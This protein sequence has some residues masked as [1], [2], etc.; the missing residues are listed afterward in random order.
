MKKLVFL[1]LF[2]PVFFNTKAE[3]I[4]ANAEVYAEPGTAVIAQLYKGSGVYVSESAKGWVKIIAVVVADKTLYDEYTLTFPKKVILYDAIGQETG[5]TY[6]KFKLPADYRYESGKV[7]FEMVGYIRETEID[8]NWVPEYSL[9]K[10]IDS[11]ASKITY[12][13]LELQLSKFQF[14]L[15]LEDTTGFECWQLNDVAGLDYKHPKERL[16]LIFYESR[17]VAV[18]H[19]YPFKLKSRE[20]ILVDGRENLI[21]LRDL[22]AYEKKIFGKLFLGD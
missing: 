2:L 21:Y 12:D 11:A 16:R 10:L 14:Y 18:F 22:N 9:T 17:L 7:F 3:R 4:N 6:G 15:Q 13:D 1:I 8:T 19:K 5:R 20:V